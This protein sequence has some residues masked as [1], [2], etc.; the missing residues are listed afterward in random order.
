MSATETHEWAIRLAESAAPDESA[1]APVIADAWL[2]GGVQREQLFHKQRGPAGGFGGEVVALLPLLFHALSQ[3]APALVALLDSGAF[4]E[5][6]G[7]APAATTADDVRR[8][9]VALRDAAP[10][11]AARFGPLVTV[12][13]QLPWSLAAHGVGE[14]E[15]QS[16]A[17]GAL[18]S[19][20]ADPAGARRFLQQISPR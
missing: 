9:A 19:L 15:A 16:A 4:Q 17:L 12:C 3:A 10:D 14:R 7:A 13:Q 18:R 2:A 11:G 1:L 5:A 20:A 8:A 6:M